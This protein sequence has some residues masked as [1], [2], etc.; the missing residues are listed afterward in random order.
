MSLVVNT[1]V[2][3][4]IDSICVLSK[5]VI[6]NRR[7]GGLLTAC[8]EDKTSLVASLTKKLLL[9][10]YTL[11]SILLNQTSMKPFNIHPYLRE[12]RF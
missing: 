6:L 11:I 10:F 7:P 3:K 4:R 8:P 2:D 12:I 1:A 5:G 9:L